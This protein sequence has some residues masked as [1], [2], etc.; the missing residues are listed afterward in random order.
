MRDDADE[1]PPL[2]QTGQS[3][4]GRIQGI[5]IQRAEAFIKEQGVDP[6]GTAGHLGEP[7]GQSQ[8]DKEAFPPGKILGTAQLPGLV[9]VAD[10]QLQRPVAHFQ[11]I[12]VGHFDQL[13]VGM[14]DHQFKIHLLDDITEFF[15][16]S[17]TYQLL[18][19]GPLLEHA[20]LLF[21]AFHEQALLLPHALIVR[22]PLQA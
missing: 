19:R 5:F 9:V 17:G 10:I 12:A 20:F 22:Q 4:Q 1:L 6:R 13:A 21:D 8:A 11:H 14:G 3:T 18:Q 7:Q 2:L 16:V 15:P